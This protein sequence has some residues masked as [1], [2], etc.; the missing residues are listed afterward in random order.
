MRSVPLLFILVQ[1][2]MV[3]WYWD[4]MPDAKSCCSTWALVGDGGPDLGSPPR[5]CSVQAYPLAGYVASYWLS[6][7][8]MA[9]MDCEADSSLAYR[10]MLPMVGMA[11][12]IRMAIIAI[13]IS[14]SMSVKPLGR[15]GRRALWRTRVVKGVLFIRSISLNGPTAPAATRPNRTTY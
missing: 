13:T 12:S 6:A 3:N 7:M 2:P 10:F 9:R 1:L 14:N 11:M 4:L 15:T 5:A 8:L